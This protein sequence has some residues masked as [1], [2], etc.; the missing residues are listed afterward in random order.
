MTPIELYRKGFQALVDALGYVDA[1]RF[2]R[3]F[4][5]GSGD[6]TEERHQWLDQVTMDEI[7]ADIKKHQENI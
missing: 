6:Y 7:L 1:I 5:N 4:D 3:Q 2:I